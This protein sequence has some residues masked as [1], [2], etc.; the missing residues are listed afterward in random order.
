M[1]GMRAVINEMSSYVD[2]SHVYGDSDFRADLLRQKRTP[3]L[4][5]IP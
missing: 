1:N 5:Y 3:Y 4:R 2:A